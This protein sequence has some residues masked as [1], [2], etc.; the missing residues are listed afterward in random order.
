M[1][2]HI[3]ISEN[4]DVFVYLEGGHLKWRVINTLS[5]KNCNGGS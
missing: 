3:Q 2:E 5:R 4:Q 1:S